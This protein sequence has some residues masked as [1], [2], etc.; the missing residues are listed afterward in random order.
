MAEKAAAEKEAQEVEALRRQ[1]LQA[2]N[3]DINTEKVF[4]QFCTSC[5]SRLCLQHQVGS[6]RRRRSAASRQMRRESSR[7]A[8]CSHCFLAFLPAFFS[9][10]MQDSLFSLELLMYI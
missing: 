5:V 9:P 6:L 8:F 3:D 7:P 4:G 10:T 1:D 2:Y